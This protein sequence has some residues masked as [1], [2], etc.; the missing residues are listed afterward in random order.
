VPSGLELQGLSAHRDGN[1]S[2]VTCTR[3]ECPGSVLYELLPA[4]RQQLACVPA[5]IE[6]H[7]ESASIAAGGSATLSVMAS[8]NGPHSYQWYRGPSSNAD[9]PVE[10]ANEAALTVWPARPESYWVRVSNA[11]G[12]SDSS[13][14]IVSIAVPGRRRVVKP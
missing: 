2:P 4:L 5:G 3:T 8:G 13:A 10:G 11:C 6:R 12:T 1:S 9:D 14:A 7:P